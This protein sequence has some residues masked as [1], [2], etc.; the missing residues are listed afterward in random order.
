MLTKEVH[1][2]LGDLIVLRS[3]V[4]YDITSHDCLSRAKSSMAPEHTRV[5]SGDPVHKLIGL[6]EP[7]PGG[8]VP[9]SSSSAKR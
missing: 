2:L 4:F 3:Q 5:V 1:D 6:Y 9:L 7:L 8:A